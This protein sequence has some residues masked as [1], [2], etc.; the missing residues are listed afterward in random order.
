MSLGP[1]PLDCPLMAPTV[2]VSSVAPTPPGAVATKKDHETGGGD[3]APGQVR[4]V[5]ATF[6]PTAA[7]QDVSCTLTLTATNLTS[8]GT[9]RAIGRGM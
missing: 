9:I 8:P 3:I 2:A 5:N 4:T 7:S 6:T 1:S